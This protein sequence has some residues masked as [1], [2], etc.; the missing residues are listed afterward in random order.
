MAATASMG[1][2]DFSQARRFSPAAPAVFDRPAPHA[3][4]SVH[5]CGG[6]GTA[7]CAL[8]YLPMQR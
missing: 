7:G 8:R 4:A 1:V 2:S 3:T 6:S 5:G